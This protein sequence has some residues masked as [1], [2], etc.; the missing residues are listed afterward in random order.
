MGRD[1]K[2]TATI[3]DSTMALVLLPRMPI[4]AYKE[5]LNIMSL[6]SSPR[7]RADCQSEHHDAGNELP[8]HHDV[9]K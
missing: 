9:P 5:I 7:K 8:E 3:Y 2:D 1:E 6:V 4:D